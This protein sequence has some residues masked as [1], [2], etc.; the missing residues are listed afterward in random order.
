MSKIH[1]RY[2]N[3]AKRIREDFTGTLKVIMKHESEIERYK[4][5]IVSMMEENDKYIQ[6]NKEKTVDQ[7]K[8][9]LND[10]LMDIDTRITRIN[11]KLSGSLSKIDKLKEESSSL[12]KSIQEKYPKL[13]KE[14]IQGQVFDYLEKHNVD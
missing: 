1:E 12:Y 4:N 14:E 8:K 6:N 9:E 11:D 5:E 2:L 10:N 13:S 3:E 7:I